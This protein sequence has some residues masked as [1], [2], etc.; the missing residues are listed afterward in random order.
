[1]CEVSKHIET[2]GEWKI[3]K[4]SLTEQNI[5]ERAYFKWLE[6]G[7]PDGND[8]EFWLSAERE[9]LYPTFSNLG[10]PVMGD[11]FFY[12][13]SDSKEFN[14]PV[15]E[16]LDCSTTEE[17]TIEK[18]DRY[19]PCV[20]DPESAPTWKRGILTRYGKKLLAKIKGTN[21]DA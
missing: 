11:G 9:L 12:Y 8:N 6:A 10:P 17:V 13:P 3:Y 2:L 19:T 14:S 18:T 15:V 4:D 5:R 1:M 16:G 21:A 20:L 7:C